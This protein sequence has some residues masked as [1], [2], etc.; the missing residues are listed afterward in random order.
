M[1]FAA[2]GWEPV[3]LGPQVL[4]AETAALAAVAILMNAWT[5]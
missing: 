3:S 2:A 4:R 5:E 1:P